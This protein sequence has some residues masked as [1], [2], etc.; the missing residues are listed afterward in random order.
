MKSFY[1]IMLIVLAFF[2]TISILNVLYISQF[3]S[4]STIVGSTYYNYNKTLVDTLYY[5][6]IIL[7]IVSILGIILWFV[8]VPSLKIQ[9]KELLH[10][11]IE[12]EPYQRV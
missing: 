3:R 2:L 12:L 1:P 5:L 7:I 9:N 11:S 6:N 8:H 10:Q 4:N